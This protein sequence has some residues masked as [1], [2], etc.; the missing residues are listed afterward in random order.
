[1]III[2][3]GGSVITDKSKRAKYQKIT[4]SLVKQISRGNKQTILIHGAGSYGHPFAKKYSL[5]KGL[6]SKR[7]LK[8]FSVTHIKVRELNLKV[9]KTM[10]RAGMKPL[11]IP[12]LN[13]LYCS[14]GVVSE[15]NSDLFRI[16]LE[17]GFTPVTF[18]D[19]VIDKFRGCSICSGD[20]LAETLT[21]I[22][23]PDKVIFVMDVDGL[24]WEDPNKPSA[25]LVRQAEISDLGR[26]SVDRQLVPDV[27]GGMKGK[28]DAIR[29]IAKYSEVILI[30]GKEP[31]RVYKAMVGEEFVGTRIRKVE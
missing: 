10:V 8:G 21:K 16:A 6:F 20:M 31:K 11:S 22:F 9:T 30:N 18:G 25:K 23:N 28:I 19:V 27:T 29:S 12:P 14:S 2:K 24:Y 15:F 5:D 26:I 1:M 7:Q 3:L 13:I 17:K 4:Q